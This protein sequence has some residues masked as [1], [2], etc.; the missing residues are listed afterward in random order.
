MNLSRNFVPQPT[1]ILLVDLAY[2]NSFSWFPRVVNY[3]LKQLKGFNPSQ[4]SKKD[5]V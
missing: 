1:K 2:K 4:P 5:K 3:K